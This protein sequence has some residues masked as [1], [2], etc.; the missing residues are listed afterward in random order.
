M[1]MFVLTMNMPTRG[2]HDRPGNPTH[3]I[4]A[5]HPAKDLDSFMRVISSQEFITVKEHYINGEDTHKPQDDLVINTNL[6]G[7]AAV[8]RPRAERYGR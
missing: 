1:T 7:K 6:I 5:E 3:Q 2:T 8:F 4:H